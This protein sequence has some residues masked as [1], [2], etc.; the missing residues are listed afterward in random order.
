MNKS[1]KTFLVILG[2]GVIALFNLFGALQWLLAVSLI[3]GGAILLAFLIAAIY[4]H[5]G[6]SRGITTK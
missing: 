1:Q 5:L 4:I 3:G 2:G 6:K